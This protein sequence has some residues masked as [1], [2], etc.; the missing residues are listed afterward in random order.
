[1]SQAVVGIFVK[2]I[3]FLS[4][5]RLSKRDLFS[6]KVFFQKFYVKNLLIVFLSVL[7]VIVLTIARRQTIENFFQFSILTGLTI[8]SSMLTVSF[9][10]LMSQR[11]C[12]YSC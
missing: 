3:F 7:G 12:S 10:K 6:M 8:T 9:S 2:K 5:V 4:F 1:M 11:D